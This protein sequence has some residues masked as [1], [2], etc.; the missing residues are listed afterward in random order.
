MRSQSVREQWSWAVVVGVLVL[1]ASSAAS[2]EEVGNGV[3]GADGQGVRERVAHQIEP[4]AKSEKEG[5]EPSAPVGEPTRVSSKFL[6]LP[7]V[8]LPC[9]GCDIYEATVGALTWMYEACASNLGSG[10][11]RPDPRH[12]CGT[13]W[14]QL[15]HA[16]EVLEDC[17]QQEEAMCSGEVE[18]VPENGTGG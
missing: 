11:G 3:R 8:S 12:A 7:E 13:L 9:F 5:E 14:E 4:R 2:G 15:Q 10:P 18:V 1:V 16:K 6:D 17:R